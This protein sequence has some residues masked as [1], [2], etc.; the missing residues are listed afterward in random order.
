MA[1]MGGIWEMMQSRNGL[2]VSQLMALSVSVKAV[3]VVYKW[4]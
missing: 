4:A 3:R 1:G 2:S